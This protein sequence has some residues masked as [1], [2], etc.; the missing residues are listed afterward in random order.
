MRQSPQASADGGGDYYSVG[1]S[2]A[3][4]PAVASRC[5]GGRFALGAGL[6]MPRSALVW[7]ALG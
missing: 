7:V 2:P 3:S 6:L 4:G 1:Y 5:L